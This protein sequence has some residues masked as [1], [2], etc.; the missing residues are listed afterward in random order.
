[1]K[2]RISPVKMSRINSA[3]L[4]LRAL[5]CSALILSFAIPAS[6]AA[7]TETIDG[8]VHIYNND[9]PAQGVETWQVKE[10]W[11]AGGEDDESVLFGLIGQ[12]EIG[13]DGTVYLLDNQLSQ[14]QVYSSE[15]EFL[16]T[17][18]GPGE[19]PGEV[20]NPAAIAVLEDGGL[21]LVK[22]MP[23]KLVRL[24]REGT[25]IGDF[26]PAGYE[27]SEG[28]ISLALRCYPAGDNLVFGGMKLVFDQATASQTR[29]YHIRS[30]GAD[31]TQIAEFYKKEVIW[32]FRNFVM[33]EIDTDFPW[34]RMAVSKD[35]KI[36]IAPERYGY[37]IHVYELDG[38]LAKVIHRE[39]KSYER[40][41]A[42]KDLVDRA[43]KAQMD[44]PQMPANSKYEAEILEPDVAELRVAGNG[45]IWV[46]NSWQRWQG[47]SNQFTYDVFNPAGEFV[48]V[49]RVECPGSVVDDRLF[50]SKDNRIIKV[51]GFLAAAISAQ[52]LGGEDEEEAEAMAITCYDRAN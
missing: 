41:Q 49:V 3:G 9:K 48:K 25:P 8:V 46:Q 7:K 35:G 13:D 31:N 24:D 38:T 40:D 39:Y 18:G 51:T 44:N 19:G 20:S 26:V 36:Y 33:R 21:G 28:G 47:E 14:V 29:G 34:Q 52:G 50:F 2:A 16:S 32:D 12:V 5:M 11:T 27:A 17:M 43:F 10:R 4:F 42:M 37:D 6:F 30:Y 1:M 23:G 15:G 45:D 22:T